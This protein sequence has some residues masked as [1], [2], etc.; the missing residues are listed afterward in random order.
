[1]SNNLRI[2]YRPLPDA[3]PQSEL[4]ALAAV[5][6]FLIQSHENRKAAATGG[7]N[8]QEKGGEGDCMPGPLGVAR[9]RLPVHEDEHVGKK[10]STVR[11][12]VITE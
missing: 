8:D 4:E 9:A 12:E 10:R 1:M 7:G 2:S 6:S 11:K 5:Y 3:T